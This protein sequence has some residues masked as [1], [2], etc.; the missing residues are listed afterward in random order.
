MGGCYASG[1]RNSNKIADD[2]IK[3][4]WQPEHS[5]PSVPSLTRLDGPDYGGR[6]IGYGVDRYLDTFI[7]PHFEQKYDSLFSEIRKEMETVRQHVIAPMQTILNE[8]QDAHDAYL[9]RQRGNAG[10]A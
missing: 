6:G 2:D 4:H 3:E 5:E 1:N 10:T 9:A 8:N 7:K